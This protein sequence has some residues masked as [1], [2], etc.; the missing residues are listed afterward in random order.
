MTLRHEAC[1][2]RDMTHVVDARHNEKKK[3]KKKKKKA[4]QGCACGV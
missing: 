4:T 1:I 2:I 3:K